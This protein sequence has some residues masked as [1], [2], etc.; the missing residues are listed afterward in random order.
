VFLDFPPDRVRSMRGA[1]TIDGSDNALE[2]VHL[3]VTLGGRRVLD[4]LTFAVPAGSAMAIIGP[5]GA[6]KTV[7]FRALI[8]AL[9][10]EG[11]IRWARETRIGYVPQK[12]AIDRDLPLTGLEFL[13]AKAAVIRAPAHDIDRVLDLLGVSAGSVRQPIGTLSGGHAQRLLIAFALL[14]SPTVLMFDEPTVGVDESG[15]RGILTV[16]EQLRGGAGLTVLLISHDAER[17]GNADRVLSIPL[18]P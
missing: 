10:F 12:L 14:G 16:I 5:N 8:G 9:P 3:A 4:D 15:G 18:R 13:R 7:L 11:A 2:V 17:R 1:R 6:G